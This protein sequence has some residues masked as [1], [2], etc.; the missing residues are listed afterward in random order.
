MRTSHREDE[1]SRCRSSP[2]SR[3]GART[4]MNRRFLVAILLLVT[5]G[6]A[7][8]PPA[9]LARS[10]ADEE[11]EEEETSN[12]KPDAGGIAIEPSR[13]KIAMPPASGFTFDVSS[14][15]CSSSASDRA[16]AAGGF[17]ARPQVT[18]SRIATKNR[19]F[20]RVLAPVLES[21]EDRHRLRS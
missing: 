3:T 17:N 6:L 8:N 1:R 13:G 20:I 21:G 7:L 19:R 14:S 15:S 2:D 12:V 4:R 10:D 16:R 11:Q 18:R 5:C 9:A